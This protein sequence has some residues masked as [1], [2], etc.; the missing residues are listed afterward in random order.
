ME[1]KTTIRQAIKYGLVGVGNTLLTLLIIWLMMKKL[2]CSDLVS[3]VVGYAVGVVN[4]FFW[5][6]QWTFKSSD[7]W[8]RSALRFGL[9]FGICYLLQLGFLLCLNKVS[10]IVDTY[11][12]QVIAMVFYTGI[13]FLMNKYFTFKEQKG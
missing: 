12:N 4:S 9:V 6:K 3:N 13:N 5:N 8:G 1:I 11:Y 7:D 2:S 10:P